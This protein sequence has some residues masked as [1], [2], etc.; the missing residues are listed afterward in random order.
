M[1]FKFQNVCDGRAGRTVLG[2]ISF[3][4][5]K[6]EGGDMCW[7]DRTDETKICSW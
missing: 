3:N 2:D 1:M 7:E 5:V 4:L 6:E